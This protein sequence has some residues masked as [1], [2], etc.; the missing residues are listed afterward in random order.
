M[1]ALLGGIVF[2]FGPGDRQTVLRASGATVIREPY[3]IDGGW[4]A[5]L[6]GPDGNYFQ[7]VTPM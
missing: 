2:F 7:W 3:Q 6:A 1:S 5:T 4:I